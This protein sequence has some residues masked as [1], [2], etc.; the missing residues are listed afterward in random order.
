M[1]EEL[2][3]TE[4][5]ISQRGKINPMEATTIVKVI[6]FLFAKNG[7]PFTSDMT[8]C[9]INTY[10]KVNSEGKKNLEIIFC[11]STDPCDTIDDD[12]DK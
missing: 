1:V 9:L 6:G 11:H 4:I 8:N 12:S 7:C 2:L 5:L 3:G 10:H